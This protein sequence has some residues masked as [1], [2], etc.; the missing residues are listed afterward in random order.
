M[1][2]KDNETAYNK[3]YDYNEEYTVNADLY[4]RIGKSTL[5]CDVLDT[6]MLLKSY[7][8]DYASMR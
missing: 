8:Y 3:V 4:V 7:F 5:M 1:I 2:V 6:E